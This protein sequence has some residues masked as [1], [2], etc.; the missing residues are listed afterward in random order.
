[1]SEEENKKDAGTGTEVKSVAS[2][3]TS[4]ESGSGGAIKNRSLSSIDAR[5]ATKSTW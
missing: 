1:M 4:I 2:V 5:A 3:E